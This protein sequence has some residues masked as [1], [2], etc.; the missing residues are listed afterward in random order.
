MIS[1]VAFK[2]PAE[3]RSHIFRPGE[4]MLRILV[5]PVTADFTLVSMDEDEAAEREMRGLRIHGS[6][7]TLAADT[8]WGS[9]TVRSMTALIAISSARRKRE[10]ETDS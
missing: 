6:R 2:A 9:S 4:P 8:T 3:G 5:L 7:P 1:F 10:P